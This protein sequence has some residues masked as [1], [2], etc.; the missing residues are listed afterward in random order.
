MTLH[1]LLEALNARDVRLSLRL[2][3][4]APRG[5][6]SE[7][8]KA[9]LIAH[10]PTLLAR[11]GRE[12]QWESL[13]ALRW[14]P[15]NDTQTDAAENGPDPYAKAEREAIRSEPSLDTTEEHPGGKASHAQT[16]APQ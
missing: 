14:G 1:D 3:V 15:A 16:K 12:A 6:L 4:D 2:V 7:Q 8:F 9:A 10:K 13:A 11:L 5:V